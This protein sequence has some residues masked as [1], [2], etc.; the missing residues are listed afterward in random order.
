MNKMRILGLVIIVIAIAVIITTV[1]DAS[2]YAD[3]NTAKKNPGKTFQ[4]IGKLD[5]KKEIKYDST[6]PGLSLGFSMT[7]DWGEACAVKYYGTKPRDFQKMEQVVV[8]GYFE[9]SIFIA[10]DLL[11]KC[12]SKYT[13]E[14]DSM[15]TFTM[16]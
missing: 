13:K 4:I 3:F 9:D 6:L 7:D 16:K 11:L 12:P 2:T 10:E 1:Y 15:K 8:T 5:K 14:P